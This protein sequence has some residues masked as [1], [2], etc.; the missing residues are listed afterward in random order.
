MNILI[1]T[2]ISYDSERIIN[3]ACS[4]FDKGNITLTS[5][6]LGE[7]ITQS[8]L[9]KFSNRFEGLKSSLKLNCKATDRPFESN[10]I[11]SLASELNIQLIIIGSHIYEDTKI[12]FLGFHIS[13]LLSGIN[14]PVLSVSKE[15]QTLAIKS[16]GYGCDLY[17][18]K[19]ELQKIIPFALAFNSL[20]HIVHVYPVFPQHVDIGEFN[21]DETLKEIKSSLKYDGL[22]FI[23]KRTQGE[24]ET[25]RGLRIY[26]TEHNPDLLAIFTRKRNPLDRIFNKGKTIKLIL[27]AKVP[28][29]S[30]PY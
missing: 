21:S 29:L 4:I 24:N 26:S 18:P 28:V 1:P 19:S 17:D 20:I 14:F 15:I 8:A 6:N 10:E 25:L 27:E 16:I 2:E 7:P 11:N 3:F 12:G 22:K 5:F 13:T 30:F 23:L 9:E